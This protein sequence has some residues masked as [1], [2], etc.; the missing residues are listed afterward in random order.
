MGFI[1]FTLFGGRSIV[2]WRVLFNNERNSCSDA[3]DDATTVDY[4][5]RAGP[6]TF[7]LK[8]TVFNR[9]WPRYYVRSY[10][11]LNNWKFIYNHFY[12][13]ITFYIFFLVCF[14][15]LIIIVNLLPYDLSSNS[16]YHIQGGPRNVC[17][18]ISFKICV[19]R[20]NVIYKSYMV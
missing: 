20:K 14:S 9:V 13:S 15:P 5:C 12:K 19:A 11:H 18:V 2:Q 10:I 6:S 7:S 16:A 17:T 3:R 8:G 1:G 4:V